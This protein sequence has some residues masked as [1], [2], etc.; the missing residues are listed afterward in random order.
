MLKGKWEG[1]KDQWYMYMY[2]DCVKIVN[3]NIP[4]LLPG[5]SPVSNL[6]KQE[7]EQY[8]GSSCNCCEHR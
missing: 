6:N 1:R 2:I 4:L 3:W 8:N 7:I 5:V